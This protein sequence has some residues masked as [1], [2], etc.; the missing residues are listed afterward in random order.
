MTSSE[1]GLTVLRDIVMPVLLDVLEQD[2]LTSFHLQVSGDRS[3][4]RSADLALSVGTDTF[5]LTVY[6]SLTMPTW[7][8]S[9]MQQFLRDALVDFVAESAFGWGQNRT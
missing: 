3:G 5:R 9:D 4:I 8:V 2:E 6:D 1:T 7:S